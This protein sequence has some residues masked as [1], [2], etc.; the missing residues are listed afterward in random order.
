M[1]SYLIKSLQ[2][3]SRQR[4]LLWHATTPGDN[5]ETKTPDGSSTYAPLG[6]QALAL[7]LAVLAAGLIGAPERSIE[8][9]FAAVPSSALVTSLFR[10]LGSIYLVAAA[11]CRRLASAA[12]SGRLSS[13]TYKRLSLGVVGS[14][15]ASLVVLGLFNTPVHTSL[16]LKI[17]LLVTYGVSII[18]P[19]LF[20]ELSVPA[21]PPTGNPT[22]S[23][24]VYRCAFYGSILLLPALFSA[25][26]GPRD[27]SVLATSVGVLGRFTISLIAAGYLL[28]TTVYRVLQ[29]AAQRGRLGASTFKAL[30]WA[31]IVL[32]STIMGHILFGLYHGVVALPPNSSVW[33]SAIHPFTQKWGE[34]YLLAY[35][36]F[37]PVLAIVSLFNAMT[38]R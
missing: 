26:Y 13:D 23:S 36:L 1:S 5:R 18:V 35:S 32:N 27:P 6:F 30:N 19:F 24:L 37:I 4:Y 31:V 21:G 9:G 17:L 11:C 7:F 34:L 3:T 20:S 8:A 2:S 16:P 33:L 22:A 14:G 10:I 15:A 38:A 29:D 28:V 12:R 25:F